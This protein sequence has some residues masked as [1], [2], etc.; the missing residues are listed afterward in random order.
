M[1]VLFIVVDSE[2][3]LSVWAHGDIHHCQSH[4]VAS[5]LIDK[6]DTMCVTECGTLMS[7]MLEN[8]WK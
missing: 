8:S 2:S 7:K 4:V 3:C 5:V 6:D 1:I